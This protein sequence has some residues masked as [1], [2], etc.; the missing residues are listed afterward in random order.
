MSP[1]E[2]KYSTRGYERIVLALLFSATA[3]NYLDRQ[4]LSVVA[5]LLEK[6]ISLSSIDYSHVIFIFLLGYTISQALTGRLIDKTGTWLGMWLC[7]ATWSV[8]SILHGL[9]AGVV[10]F[11]ILRFLLGIAEAGNWPGAVKAVSENF[12]LHR[13]AFAIGVFNSGSTA[14]AIIAPPIVSAVTAAWGW[15]MMFAVVGLSGFLW[16]FLWVNLYKRAPVVPSE[17][18]AARSCADHSFR[19]YFHSKAVWG[20]MV[21][22]SLADPVWWFY[23]FW[24]P[25]YLAHSR[26]FSLVQIGRSAWIPFVF[27]GIGGWLGGYASDALVRQGLP[28]VSARKIVMG[29]SA[30]LM[31][32]GICASRAS[33][34]A[35]ALAWVSVVL[36]GFASWASNMLSLPIDLFG[37]HEVGQVTGL[38]GTAGAIG[39]MAFTLVTGWLAANVSYESVFVVGSGMIVCAAIVVVVLVFP[40]KLR[41]AGS[42]LLDQTI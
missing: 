36:L 39:G 7:V 16:V 2:S 12:P 35:M 9:S 23:A 20:L 22:R 33:S 25:N 3:I 42:P 17:P 27:A 6:Q 19:K 21:A 31:L 41:V 24:L 4:A 34:A 5:P 10:S 13:R 11:A 15:R 1:G 37:S 26:G 8:V 18:A 40:T 14:G 29:C 30:L 38:T 32:C 28:A